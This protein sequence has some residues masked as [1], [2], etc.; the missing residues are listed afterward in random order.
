[1]A[2]FGSQL[3]QIAIQISNGFRHRK[4][5]LEKE[6]TNLKL[7]LDQIE[8]DLEAAD[9]AIDRIH[10][11]RPN[12]GGDLRCPQCWIRQGV[13]TA[14]TPVAS[15]TGDWDDFTCRVCHFETSLQA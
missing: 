1:M 3:A 11:F 5:S 7:S 10:S 12:M 2:D 4:R 9:L 8:A 13:E 6:R 15:H 14:L